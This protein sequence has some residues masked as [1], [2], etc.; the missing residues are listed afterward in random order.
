MLYYV[1]SDKLWHNMDITLDETDKEYVIHFDTSNLINK[2]TNVKKEVIY[3]IDK[4]TKNEI[5][6]KVIYSERGRKTKMDA[7]LKEFRKNN[8]NIDEEQLI[9]AFRTFEKQ[10][11]VDYFINKNAGDFLKDQFDMYIKTYLLDDNSLFNEKRLKQLKLTKEL[12]YMIIDFVAQ[13][14]DELKK[15]WEKPKFVLNSNYVITLDKIY[16]KNGVDVIEK[17][18]N[19][20]GI[21]KQINEW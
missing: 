14:E 10:N 18:L 15:I 9:K 6:F 7:I 5:F 19:D 12:A 8:I 3:E 13:F 1:K 17:I 2:Q 21:E 20:N 16:N 11:E 4:I